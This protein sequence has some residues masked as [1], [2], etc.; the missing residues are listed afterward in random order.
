MPARRSARRARGA[1]RVRR[2]SARGSCKARRA[3]RALARTADPGQPS[4]DAI[5]ARAPIQRPRRQRRLEVCVEF[6][7]VPTQPILRRRALCDQIVAMIGQQSDL[8][9]RPIQSA[10]A[11]SRRPRAAPPEPPRQRRSA[12]DF[13]RRRHRDGACPMSFGGTRTS[14]SPR[15]AKSAPAARKRVGSP[16]SPTLARSRCDAPS[17]S[18]CSHVRALALTVR[19]P[20]P[21]GRGVDGRRR[22]ACSCEGQRRSRSSTRPFVEVPLTKRSPADRP[23]WGRLPRSYQVT[24]AILGR[25]RATEPM[26]VSPTGRQR[27]YGSARRQLRA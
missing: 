20:T 1:A 23:H 6:N 11:A 17:A 9:R 14:R 12:S 21:A 5:K 7:Q 25:R 19:S 13:P 4:R 18:S 2:R 22:Y 27:P 8:Q 10:A 26:K 24:P 3:P 15:R 16:R